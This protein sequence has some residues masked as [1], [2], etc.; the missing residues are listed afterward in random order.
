MQTVESLED[1]TKRNVQLIAEMEEKAKR[2]VGERM[3]DAVVAGVGSWAFVI[4]QTTVIA[5]WML[6]NA[7]SFPTR[8]DPYPFFL[9]GFVLSVQ[10][11]CLTPIILMSQK[12]QGR[13]S[14]RRN[15]LDLQINLL[16]EQEN[17]EQLRLLRLLCEK[18]GI[19]LTQKTIEALE[20]KT[21]PTEIV[22]QIAKHVES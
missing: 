14:E 6:L 20:Q 15:H 22:E 3:A 1:L 19:Q 16:A 12:R 10:V 17:T 4:C 21:S 13:L 2:T 9:L 5:A 11:A 8:W 7:L 18:A